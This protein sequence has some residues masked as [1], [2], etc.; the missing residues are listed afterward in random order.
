MLTA[1]SLDEDWFHFLF[2]EAKPG[3]VG[4]GL[5]RVV[6]AMRS[7]L[8]LTPELYV[9]AREAD[10]EHCSPIADVATVYGV[11][12]TGVS[13]EVHCMRM[14]LDDDEEQAVRF[15]SIADLLLV[16]ILRQIEV[17]VLVLT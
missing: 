3:G 9:K 12:V 1:V 17:Q 8:S 10:A 15:V 5:L 14:E 7:A 6:T 2:I 11:V 16:W 13:C 4:P